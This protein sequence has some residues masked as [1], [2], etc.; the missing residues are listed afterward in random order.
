[1][2]L[3]G[4]KVSR[5]PFPHIDHGLVKVDQL[6]HIYNQCYAGLSLS[7]T[8]VSLVPYEML[9]AGCIPVVNDASHNRVVLDNPYVEYADPTPHAL[10]RAVLDIVERRDP[11][12]VETLASS[13]SAASW[14]AAGAKVEAVLMRECRR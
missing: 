7:M 6:N 2:H 4:E 5:L 8:N 9:A 1:M 14:S 13:V 11:T 3:Y 10:A 12:P